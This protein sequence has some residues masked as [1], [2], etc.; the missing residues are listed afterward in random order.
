MLMRSVHR[1]AYLHWLLCSTCAGSA[2]GGLQGSFTRSPWKSDSSGAQ[3]AQS[4]GTVMNEAD[5]PTSS[6]T[7]PVR[8]SLCAT[9]LQVSA[10]RQQL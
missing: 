2:D 3:A 9:Q 5:R 6:G 4:H 8:A 1:G 7:R 10:P